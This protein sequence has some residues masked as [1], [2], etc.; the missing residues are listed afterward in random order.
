M[1]S[2]FLPDTHLTKHPQTRFLK[3]GAECSQW[4][5][6]TWFQ[7]LELDQYQSHK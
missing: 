5:Y 4:S 3:I 2:F 7:D 1:M 6:L